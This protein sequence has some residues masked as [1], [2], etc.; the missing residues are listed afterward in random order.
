MR[1]EK[2]K[3][4]EKRDEILFFSIFLVSACKKDRAARYEKGSTKASV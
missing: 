2:K 4:N 1:K 3:I